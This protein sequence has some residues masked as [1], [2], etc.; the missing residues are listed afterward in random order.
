MLLM[1]MSVVALM[2]VMNVI[3]KGGRRVSRPRVMP[4]IKCP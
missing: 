1:M 4:K 2:I 3:S